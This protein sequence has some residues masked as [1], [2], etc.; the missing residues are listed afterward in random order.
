MVNFSPASKNINVFE[1]LKYS[2]TALKQTGNYHLVKFYSSVSGE[3]IVVTK[4]DYG[5]V[6]FTNIRTRLE[7]SFDFNSMDYQHYLH[8]VRN[9]SDYDLFY[10]FKL[11]G[12]Q[13]FRDRIFLFKNDDTDGFNQ[14]DHNHETGHIYICN[15]Y[16]IAMCSVFHQIRILKFNSDYTSLQVIPKNNSIYASI[17]GFEKFKP[18]TYNNIEYLYKIEKKTKTKRKD[19]R[20]LL[21]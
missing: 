17:L 4:N 5:R 13:V 6:H 16:V 20:L 9:G 15:E 21:N 3:P 14:D 19:D 12:I 1:S 18:I 8:F 2:Y 10:S 7:T 11:G